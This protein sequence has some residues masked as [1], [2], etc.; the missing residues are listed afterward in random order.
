MVYDPVQSLLA[1][2]TSSSN[3]GPGQVY[4]FGNKR[5]SC[6]LPLAAPRASVKVLQ[7]CSDK[8]LCLDDK[9]DLSIYSLVD[10]KLVASYSPPGHVTAIASDHTLDYVILGM[11]NGKKAL[12]QYL[13]PVIQVRSYS[14]RGNFLGDLLAYDLD[15]ENLAPFKIPCLLAERNPKARHVPIVSLEFHPRDI[16]KILVGYLECAV[17]FSFKQNAP[18]SFFQYHL[19][20]GAPG[21]DANP[22][23]MSIARNPRLTQA[24]WHPTGTFILTGHEDSSLVVWDSYDGRIIMARTLTDTNVDKP[25]GAGV[26]MLADSG[27]VSPRT[28]LLKIAWCA[29]EDPDDTGEWL[30][31]H[32]MIAILA[33]KF[34]K[35]ILIAGG[36]SATIPTKGLTFM[37]LGRTPNYTTSSWQVLSNHFE[38]PKRQRIL[39]TPPNVEVTNFCLIPRKSP[40]YAGAQDPVALLAVLSSGEITSMSFPSGFPISPTNQLHLSLTFVH[41][42]VNCVGYNAVDR[43]RWLGSTESRSAG[44]KYLKGGAEAPRP[45][46]RSEERNIIQT[47]HADGTVRL[48]DAGHG[49]EVE[50]ERLLQADVCRAVGRIDQVHMTKLSYSGAS[51]ELAAGLQTGEVAIFR[52]QRNNNPGVE[53]RPGGQNQPYTLTNITD[54]K[55]PS[56]T[57]GLHPFTLMNQQE[58]RVTALKVSD[59]GFIAAGFEGGSVAIVDMR[60]PAIIFSGNV[61]EIIRKEKHAPLR[62]KSVGQKHAWPTTLEF[63]VMTLED[64]GYS[65]ILLHA[66]TSAGGVVTFKILPGQGGR[67]SV[68]MAGFSSLEDPVISIC[69]FNTSTGNSAYATQMAVASLRNGARIDGVVLAVSKSE[70]RLFRPP[71]ARGAHK[72]WSDAFCESANV[73]KCLDRG[74]AIVGLFADGLARAYSLP[75]LSEIASLRVGDVLDA[76]KFQD[77]AISGTGDIIA[78]TGPSEMALLNVWGTGDNQYGLFET[79][80]RVTEVLTVCVG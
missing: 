49:D 18:K 64:E 26:G 31:H 33:E 14:D 69:P 22:A 53:P 29:K 71:S 77:A 6:T 57:E 10:K 38:S 4:V 15:R 65:S 37:E 78:W 56:L 58:G 36:T 61:N 48:W 34:N 76:R 30:L 1:V 72:T 9:N 67:Y 47:A 70:A 43:P 63:S 62:R 39:P 23:S 21:G 27:K 80:R 3:F 35:G 59:V 44:P 32:C 55:D 46:K 68:S 11:G 17:I 5:I 75:G 13:L 12:P 60:G 16:G 79:M 20:R 7:F 51:G 41:P 45:L 40:W 42:F 50:N 2:G 52:W 24:V 28:P 19:P 25:G 66:G 54:R 74:S 73:T 8:L